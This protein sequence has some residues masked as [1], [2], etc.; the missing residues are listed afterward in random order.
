MRYLVSPNT[1]SAN[2]SGH[3]LSRL[4]VSGIPSEHSDVKYF[5][6][7]E[8]I[9]FSKASYDMKKHEDLWKST[10]KDGSEGRR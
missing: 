4:V 6:G 8:Q 9:K 2:E 1:H 5:S 3:A 10:F 7:M